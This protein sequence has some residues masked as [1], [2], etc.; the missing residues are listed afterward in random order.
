MNCDTILIV[1]DDAP[2]ADLLK[3][4]LE[5]EGY[6]ALIARDGREALHMAAREQPSLLLLDLIL[7]DMEGYEVVRRLKADDRTSHLPV[8]ILTARHDFDDKLQGLRLGALEYLT[9]PFERQELTYRVRNILRF[10][11]ASSRRQAGEQ[12]P[13]RANDLLQQMVERHVQALIPKTNRRARLGFEYPE[14]AQIFQPQ[15]VGDEV[16]ELEKLADQ[17]VLERVFFDSIHLCP[18]CG[19]HDLNFRE[20]CPSCESPEISQS[21]LAKTSGYRCNVCGRSF[22]EPVV[23][24][25]CMAC[26]HI[27]DVD[28]AIKQSVYSY[29]LRSDS[30]R[31]LQDLY[32][33]G[34]ERPAES[35]ASPCTQLPEENTLLTYIVQ[36]LGIPVVEEESLEQRLEQLVLRAEEENQNITLVALELTGLRTLSKKMAQQAM[37]RLMGSVSRILKRCVRPG[38]LATA[39]RGDQLVLI[40]P[41]TPMGIARIVAERIRTYLFELNENLG[42]KITLANFPEDGSNAREVVEIL[43]AGIVTMRDDMPR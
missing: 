5:K 3:A 7:P 2:T 39:R 38:D 34:A 21:T 26:D 40:L 20:V 8:V 11:D 12:P 6:R 19:H 28:E 14:A 37:L 16:E 30:L 4:I 1:E 18:S 31:R 33:A 13:S 36:R 27:F 41:N 22:V 35:P 9:K 24:C 25:R 29:R 32:G 43:D 23:T 17:H 10:C 15:N 42:C